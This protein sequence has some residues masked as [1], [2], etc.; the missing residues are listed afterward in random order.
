[1]C[2]N[3]SFLRIWLNLLK[4]SLMENFTFCAVFCYHSKPINMTCLCAICS[5]SRNRKQVSFTMNVNSITFSPSSVKKIFEYNI[6]SSGFIFLK[7][8]HFTE[9]QILGGCLKVFMGQK[10]LSLSEKYLTT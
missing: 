5:Y 9:K 8:T 2:P 3:R 10:W 4:K 7:I 6:R 1:M